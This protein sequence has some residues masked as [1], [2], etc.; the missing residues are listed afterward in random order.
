MISTIANDIGYDFVFLTGG[1]LVDILSTYLVLR[2]P[3]VRETNIQLKED[4]KEGGLERALVRDTIRWTAQA[5]LF[6]G[7]T[8]TIDSV[9]GI[10]KNIFNF[11]HV[12]TYV[13]GTMSYLAG[14]SNLALAYN[15]YKTS[16]II[17]Y[18]NRIIHSGWD[19][20]FYKITGQHLIEH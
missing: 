1:N 11:H 16:Q 17:D 9:L 18:P 19:S 6:L 7:L 2:K 5:A 12:L 13:R 8:Y 10:E 4:I 14:L 3:D 15:F 20:I